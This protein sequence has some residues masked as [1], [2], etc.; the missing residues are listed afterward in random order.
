MKKLTILFLTFC[1]HV[2]AANGRSGEHGRITLASILNTNPASLVAGVMPIEI[3]GV[4]IVPHYVSGEIPNFNDEEQYLSKYKPGALIRIFVKNTDP[5]AAINPTILVNGKTGKELIKS[6]IV[7]YCDLP[8]IREVETG[9]STVIPSHGI[10][11]YLLN[12]VDS[13]FYSD[14]ILLKF[15]DKN[16]GLTV[17]KKI[18]LIK[19]EI[20]AS[21]IVFTSSNGTCFPDGFLVY[22]NNN[23]KLAGEV[24][25][26]TIWKA[27]GKVTDH[28][29]SE[30]VVQKDIKWFGEK[31][32]IE[33]GSINGASVNTGRLPFGEIVL[34]LKIKMGPVLKTL[35]YTVKP[36]VLNFDIG[37]G[38]G[39][40]YLAAS[41]AFCKTVKFMHFNTVN[42]DAA[43]FLANTEWAE[44]YPMKRFSKL[45]KEALTT[46]AKKLNTI[47]GSEF[48]GEPQF[49]KKP[50][51]EIFNYYTSY[52]NS[53][54]PTTL[55]LSHEPGF[56]LYAGVVDLVHFDAYR[57]VA[58]HADKW[59][60]YNKYGEKNVK[61]GAPLET[62]GDYMRT[63]NRISY[64]NPVAAWAQAMSDNWRSRYRPGGGNPNNHEM[65]VQA[66]EAIAN[67]AAS[68]YWFNMSGKTIVNNRPSLAEIHRINRELTVLGDLLVRADPY[69]FQ[70]RFKD[71]D[72]NV[73]AG[74]DYALLF[75]IDL[76]YKVSDSNQFVSAGKRSASLTFKIP[77]YL[78]N[79]NSALKVTHEGVY[80]VDVK[81]MN[82]TASIND[83]FETTGVYLL[84]NK[85]DL[86]LAN[87]IK[88]KFNETLANEASYRFDP[89]T[90]DADFKVLTDEVN[91]VV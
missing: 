84:F 32:K 83:S 57:V 2:C 85:A 24:E 77:A 33:A 72:L 76:K 79:C 15:T 78:Q 70:N 43:N 42:G 68:L 63:L 37:M 49:S 23:A 54:F 86:G 12:V 50:A 26:I 55:T 75:A 71:I 10:D 87:K 18:E 82:G 36:I 66:Y 45:Q 81:V 61:W 29:W 91:K 58:P 89:I 46:D 74:P 52:R 17:T 22:L 69:W 13:N 30:S 7:S 48:F 34:E 51:N 90:N 16:S 67:G 39:D 60:N 40:R 11:C 1:I 47:H 6:N 41:E 64:P 14:G 65:R 59:G 88:L 31:R 25:D 8:D 19:P 73:L 35:F 20:F 5:S 21:R 28:W 56:F 62:I 4:T 44:K 53:G 3:A 38:W 80:K 9:M 27:P